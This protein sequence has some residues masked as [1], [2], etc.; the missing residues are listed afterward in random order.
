MCCGYVTAGQ[1]ALENTLAADFGNIRHT[2]EA[3]AKAP[4]LGQG[5]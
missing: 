1:R 4:P 5:T 2:S 3:S